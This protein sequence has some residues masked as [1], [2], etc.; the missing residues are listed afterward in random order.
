MKLLYVLLLLICLSNYSFADNNI[1]ISSDAKLG[2]VR[3]VNGIATNIEI[4]YIAN[5]VEFGYRVNF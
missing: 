5:I 1:K 3:S 4:G 2:G